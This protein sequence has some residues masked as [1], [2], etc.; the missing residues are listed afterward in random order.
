MLGGEVVSDAEAVVFTVTQADD[1]CTISGPDTVP[2]DETY[3][4]VVENP[5]EEFLDLYVSLLA[6][7]HTYQEFVELQ[8]LRAER[9]QA[10][11]TDGQT[12][13]L[14]ESMESEAKHDGAKMIKQVVDE[15]TAKA[16]VERFGFRRRGQ[17]ARMLHGD[18]RHRS[19]FSRESALT[20]HCHTVCRF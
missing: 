13:K 4:V 12:V 8:A 19:T 20:K 16:A 3:F 15:A 9:E 14:I 10:R 18:Q 1:G 2:A 6:D 17:S 7:G 5:T 11:K